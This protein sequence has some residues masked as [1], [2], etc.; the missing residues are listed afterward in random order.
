MK[1]QMPYLFVYQAPMHTELA[2][3]LG[4]TISN[5]KP[6]EVRCIHSLFCNHLHH[7]MCETYMF[8]SLSNFSN[9]ASEFC[10]VIKFLLS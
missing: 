1:S 10:R 8:E 6:N 5:I 2:I 4:L 3:G 7:I 9:I